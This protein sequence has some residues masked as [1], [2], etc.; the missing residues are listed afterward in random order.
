MRLEGDACRPGVVLLQCGEPEPI[1]FVAA[2]AGFKGCN[3]TVLNKLI[4]HFNM[5]GRLRGRDALKCVLAKT[6]ALIRHLLP[7]ASKE[8]ITTFLKIRSGI[9]G[10]GASILFTGENLQQADAT[11]GPSDHKE[12]RQFKDTHKSDVTLKA[13]T[14]KYISDRGLAERSHVEQELTTIGA[15]Q[16]PSATVAKRPPAKLV[17]SWTETF[18]KE[19]IPQ[20]KGATI[21]DANNMHAVCW[22][23][24]YAG[25]KPYGSH[26]CSYSAKSGRTSEQA[27]SQCLAWIWAQHAAKTGEQCPWDLGQIL[28]ATGAA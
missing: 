18:L 19:K 13:T 14:L 3:E 24:R 25:A 10:E 23:A 26:S 7:G 5:G 20:T 21:Q 9:T 16:P 28:S 15:R 4:R 27:A 22:I 17:W 8:D 6:E 2:R 1:E 11:F 12:A